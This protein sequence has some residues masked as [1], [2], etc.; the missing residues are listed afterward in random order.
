MERVFTIGAYGFTAECFFAALRDA[1]V[2]LFLDLRRRRGVRGAEY[3]FANAGRLKEQLRAR[4]TAYC[5]VLDLAPDPSTREIQNR[6]DAKDGVPR[7]SRAALA[8]D[9]IEAYE[10]RTVGPFDWAAF[11]RDL[12][13]VERPVLFCVERL[14]GACHR[15][16]VAAEL[17]RLMGIPVQHLVP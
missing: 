1:H 10:S 11:I 8:P 4:G 7:R 9:F 15:H 5:H 6:A 17:E 16:L 3:T 14:P 13:P 2:D 12:G